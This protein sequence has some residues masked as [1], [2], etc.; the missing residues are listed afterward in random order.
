MKGKIIGAILIVLLLVVGAFL[1]LHSS[2]FQV[3]VP[4]YQKPP[5]QMV[6]AAQGWTEDQR[7]HFHHT[8]QGTRLVPYDWFMALEQPCLSLSGCDLLADK[9]YLARFGF[10]ASPRDSNSIRMGYLL[11]LPGRKT[12]MIQ[13][14]RRHIQSWD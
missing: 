8:P 11:V 7:L 3:M 10:L 2:Q 12:F 13:K 1:F 14:P 5:E 6:D 9:T 4:E